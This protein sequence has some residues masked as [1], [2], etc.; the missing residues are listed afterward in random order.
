MSETGIKDRIT[1]ASCFLLKSLLPLEIQNRGRTKY[2][3][4]SFFPQCSLLQFWN[5]KDQ[6]GQVTWR[7]AAPQRG[8]ACV[9][10]FALRGENTEW[11]RPTFQPSLISQET[12]DEGG[13]EASVIREGNKHASSPRS[14]RLGGER[15]SC[16][17]GGLITKTCGNIPASLS[18]KPD[19]G[20]LATGSKATC[21]QNSTWVNWEEREDHL[22]S[23]SH[24]PVAAG[25][26]HTPSDLLGY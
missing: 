6:V 1:E 7:S 5:S 13:W 9:M 24:A 22:S 10:C 2:L 21:S 14:A 19:G 4:P 8:L 20:L 16:G 17:G 18:P 26:E 3:H 11:L 12:E 15:P 25:Q 23:H